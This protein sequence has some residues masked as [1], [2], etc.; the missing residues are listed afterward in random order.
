MATVT[1]NMVRQLAEQVKPPRAVI[2]KFPFGAPLGDPL[3]RGL[4]EKVIRSALDLLQTA[5]R[6]GIIVDLP[7]N[8]KENVDG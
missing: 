4:Q 6:P 1:V 5:D 3:N 2:T 7:Y 8:W